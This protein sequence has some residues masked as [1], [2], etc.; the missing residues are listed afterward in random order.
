MKRC[1]VVIVVVWVGG[2]G[3]GLSHCNPSRHAA[4]LKSTRGAHS[5]PYTPTSMAQESTYYNL[6]SLSI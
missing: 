5:L 2:C 3:S 1:G 4:A 6:P